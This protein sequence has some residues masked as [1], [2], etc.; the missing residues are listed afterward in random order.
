MFSSRMIA[1]VSAALALASLS[2]VMAVPVPGPAP[3]ASSS[4]AV[5]I[6][7]P[8]FVTYS[9]KFVDQNVLPPASELAVST[10]C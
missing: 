1:S 2:S 7:S 8:A 10:N 9:D 3:L 4:R 6:P 5:S